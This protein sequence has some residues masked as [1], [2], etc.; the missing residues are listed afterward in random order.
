[1]ISKIPGG[2]A[3][4]AI[5][6]DAFDFENKKIAI[7]APIVAPDPPKKQNAACSPPD[8][9]QIGSFPAANK[10]T[11]SNANGVKMEKLQNQQC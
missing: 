11:F 6:L 9:V 5:D 7:I 4:V 3:N 2:V 10:A 1:L 8:T